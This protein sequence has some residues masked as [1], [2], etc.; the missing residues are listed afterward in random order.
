VFGPLAGLEMAW[1]A[2]R[3]FCGVLH[4]K[5]RTSRVSRCERAVSL[6]CGSE[7]RRAT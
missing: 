4:R 3:W 6:W 7:R 2:N 5:W 1:P